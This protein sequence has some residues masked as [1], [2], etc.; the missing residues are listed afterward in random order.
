MP[1]APRVWQAE[2][3]EPGTKYPT[4]RVVDRD[5]NVTVQG[6]FSGLVQRRVYDLSSSTP[7]TAVLSNTVAVSSVIFSSLQ[8]WDVDSEGFNFRD[9]VTSNSVAW[10][11]GHTY[12][13][14]YLLP[15]TSQGYI[16]VVFDLKTLSLL[17]L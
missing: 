16:P 17:S 4:A 8:A 1:T 15:H 7:A 6:D 2:A 3:F 11:G 13:F 14:S 5:G 10:Q 9:S 12:R